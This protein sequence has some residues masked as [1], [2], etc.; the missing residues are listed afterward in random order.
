[1]QVV[2]NNSLVARGY[3]KACLLVKSQLGQLE[4]S[5]HPET[6]CVAEIDPPEGVPHFSL[7]FF[8][9]LCVK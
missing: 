4:T 7:L 8:P 3:H 5:D 2:K 1:M 6:L 9:H